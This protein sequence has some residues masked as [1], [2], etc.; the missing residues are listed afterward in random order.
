MAVILNNRGFN[1]ANV[2]LLDSQSFEKQ[3]LCDEEINILI[4]NDVENLLQINKES[5]NKD[6]PTAISDD[7]INNYTN[8]ARYVAEDLY[9]YTPSVYK[10]KVTFFKAIK[11][12]RDF[13]G[14]PN[15]IVKNIKSK[16][17]FYEKERKNL[18]IIN[19]SCSHDQLMEKDFALEVSNGI[20]KNM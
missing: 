18:K 5:I 1:V 2:F 10:G 12:I 19:V 3:S 14:L 4:E 8:L 16:P 13:K 15:S 9:S 6:N 11:T 7:M 17:N 20:I